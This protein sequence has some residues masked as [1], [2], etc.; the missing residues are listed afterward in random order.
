MKNVFHL[1]NRATK[2]FLRSV[3]EM[4]QV[5]LCVPDHTTLSRRGTGLKV[6]LPK[7]ADG[8]LDIF[9]DSSGL[10]IFGEGGRKMHTHGKS[11]RR[12]VTHNRA[13]FSFLI[14]GQKIITK[15]I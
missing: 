3:F 4:I 12:T 15:A 11:K 7:K 6:N 14:R 5:N 13:S 10:N 1:P 2:G 9:M 8:H